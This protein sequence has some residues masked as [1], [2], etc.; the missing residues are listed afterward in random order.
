MGNVHSTSGAVGVCSCG[1]SS[2]H[3]PGRWQSNERL[4]SFL[5]SQNP[6]RGG[7]YCVRPLYCV[8]LVHP[9]WV[10]VKLRPKYKRSLETRVLAHSA[11]SSIWT[12]SSAPRIVSIH[13]SQHGERCS[14]KTVR[15]V[16][17]HVL[18]QHSNLDTICQPL[19]REWLDAP[20][21]R[22][23]TRVLTHSAMSSIWTASSAPRTI[24]RRA[25]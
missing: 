8:R 24:S 9:F 14:P 18:S 23:D 12:A 2:T 6:E 1:S 15:R 19:E 10:Q 7:L 4:R 3:E 25:S 5:S 17:P 21:G 11:M 20:F 22:L 13:E 16:A